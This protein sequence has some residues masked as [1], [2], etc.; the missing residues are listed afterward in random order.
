[1]PVIW[2]TWRVECGAG[3]AL[4]RVLEFPHSLTLDRTAPAGENHTKEPFGA[5]DFAVP[6]HMSEG[7]YE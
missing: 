6:G 3:P 5:G 4:Q 2:P 1:V 7:E